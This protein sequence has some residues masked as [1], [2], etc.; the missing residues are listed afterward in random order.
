MA[1]DESKGR[2]NSVNTC[3]IISLFILSLSFA[4]IFHNILENYLKNNVCV[5]SG[6]MQDSHVNTLMN[7]QVL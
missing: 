5:H 6:Y 7:F 2:L 1:L 3:H 4:H